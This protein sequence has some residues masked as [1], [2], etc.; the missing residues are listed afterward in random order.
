[1]LGL[2]LDQLAHETGVERATISRVE[3]GTLNP[4]EN[5]ERRLEK[6]Y[7]ES[8]TRLLA[9]IRLPDDLLGGVS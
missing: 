8:I 6:F 1:M 9:A 4:S 5:V 3:R 2:T 7:G